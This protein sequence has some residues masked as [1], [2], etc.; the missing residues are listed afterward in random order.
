MSATDDAENHSSAG[1]CNSGLRAN[2]LISASL[3]AVQRPPAG[4]KGRGE[5]VCGCRWKEKG[6]TERRKKKPG[7]MTRRRV[8]FIRHDSTASSTTSSDSL[9]RPPGPRGVVSARRAPPHPVHTVGG[10]ASPFHSLATTTRRASP[11]PAARELA[12]SPC[13]RAHTLGESALGR[14]MHSAPIHEIKARPRTRSATHST[15]HATPR[16]TPTTRFTLHAPH[17][18]IPQDTPYARPIPSP[19]DSPL[20]RADYDAVRAR[21]ELAR[22]LVLLPQLAPWRRKHLHRRRHLDLGAVDATRRHRT[23]LSPQLRPITPRPQKTCAADT[24]TT[25]HSAHPLP[26]PPPPLTPLPTRTTRTCTRSPSRLTR[27]PLSRL[28]LLPSAPSKAN[29]RSCRPRSPSRSSRSHP[30][31][32]SPNKN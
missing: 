14:G 11:C 4:K 16:Q 2:Y 32:T 31:S 26:R 24:P 21:Q 19:C 1:A 28:P 23:P 17:A 25:P 3:V 13:A 6:R 18:R 20:R 30:L 7:A 22:A 10:Y 29:R 15:R 5:L 8:P 27:T 12:G 9:R